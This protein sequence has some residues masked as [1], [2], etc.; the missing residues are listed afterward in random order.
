MLYI[1]S[2]RIEK[3]PR[4]SAG[5]QFELLPQQASPVVT[6][7]RPTQPSQVTPLPSWIVLH[8][9]KGVANSQEI[10]YD[11]LWRWYA[12]SNCQRRRTGCCHT[13]ANNTLCDRL[14][15]VACPSKCIANDSLIGNRIVTDILPDISHEA[16]AP[17]MS[18]RYERGRCSLELFSGVAIL[19]LLYCCYR[20]DYIRLENGQRA[21]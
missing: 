20:L 10:R 13:P 21:R 19:L 14:L 12:R 8:N 16:S 6:L 18:W 9:F 7:H 2:Y 3:E 5:Y 17:S 4:E 11:N 15:C 1:L